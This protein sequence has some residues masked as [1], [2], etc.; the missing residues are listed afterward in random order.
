MVYKIDGTWKQRN[1][2]I[3][4]NTRMNEYDDVT[5]KRVG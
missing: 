5:S 4:V 2:E 1:R 3:E